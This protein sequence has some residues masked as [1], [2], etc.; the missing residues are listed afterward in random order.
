VVRTKA[1][2]GGAAGGVLGAGRVGAGDAALGISQP[3]TSTTMA[4]RSSAD[5]ARRVLAGPL[6]ESRNADASC[7]LRLRTA[8]VYVQTDLRFAC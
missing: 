6:P 1:V 2:V 7:A 4:S 8:R 3:A 5:P